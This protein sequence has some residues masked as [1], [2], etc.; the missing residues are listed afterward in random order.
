MLN[1]SLSQAVKDVK[2][3]EERWRVKL[4]KVNY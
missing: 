2:A 4:I 3:A 1:A